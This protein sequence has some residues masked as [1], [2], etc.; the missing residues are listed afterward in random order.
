MKQYTLEVAL[1]EL[2]EKD[3]KITKLSTD[4]KKL[5]ADNDRLTIENQRLKKQITALM[6]Q[7]KNEKR[8]SNNL[9]IIN[10]K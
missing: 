6:I 10:N 5:S 4:N 2:G 9:R 3:G 1:K 8:M 7:V